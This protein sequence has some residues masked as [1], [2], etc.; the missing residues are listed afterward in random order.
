LVPTHHE[1]KTFSHLGS[2]KAA[3]HR[4]PPKKQFLIRPD[5]VIIGQDKEGNR[6]FFL[7]AF[8]YTEIKSFSHDDY[9]TQR[10][11]FITRVGDQLPR[12]TI[13]RI[14]KIAED[15]EYVS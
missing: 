3:P 6:D 7:T 10:F 13:K 5:I 8:P 14:K 4:E 1:R 15:V 11:D 12:K 2:A 9:T